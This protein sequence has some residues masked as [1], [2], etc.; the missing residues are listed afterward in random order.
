[1]IGL[2]KFYDN[3]YCGHFFGFGLSSD[4][5][6]TEIIFLEG[7]LNKF[8]VKDY[9]KKKNKYKNSTA[10]GDILVRRELNRRIKEAKYRSINIIQA[11]L[12]TPV[13]PKSFLSKK[14]FKY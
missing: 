9:N 7:G 12:P 4:G 5:C 2:L 10:L 6:V 11:A 1:M 13:F 14:Y 8:V 3:R